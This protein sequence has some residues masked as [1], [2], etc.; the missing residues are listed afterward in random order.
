M[1][2]LWSGTVPVGAFISYIQ[3]AR[4]S[5]ILRYNHDALKKLSCNYDSKISK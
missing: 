4:Y 5:L 2:T 1:V 3:E